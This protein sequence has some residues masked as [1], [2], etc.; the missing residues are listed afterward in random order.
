Y[1]VLPALSSDG[2][3]AL[4]IFEGSVNKDWFM[5][6]LKNE[7]VCV[8]F[9]STFVVVMDNCAIH[10]DEEVRALVEGEC[11]EFSVVGVSFNY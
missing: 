4:D 9:N 2:I 7:L 11:G 6:F 8:H 5:D 1:S 3:I 10:H